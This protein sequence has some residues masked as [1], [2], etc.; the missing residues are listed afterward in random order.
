MILIDGKHMV[1]T[2]SEEDLHRFAH[3]IGL[4]R[5]WYQ[6]HDKHPH[7]DLTTDAALLRAK[8]AGATTVSEKDLIRMAWWSK[9]ER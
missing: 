4:K 9:E 7:Y 2:T 1:S 8:K 5:S 3:R 6:A